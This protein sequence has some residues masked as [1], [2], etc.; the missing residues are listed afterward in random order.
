MPLTR[1]V[2]SATLPRD[3]RDTWFLLAV[4]GWIVVL[5]WPHVPAWCSAM[6][7]AV[8]LG[9]AWLAWRQRPLPGWPWRIALLVL[10]L[11]GTWASH[12]TWLGQ[13]AG[14]TLVM[15][16][17]ALK[18]LELRARRDA[19]VV[20]FLGFFALL[21]HFFHSQSLLTALGI[22]LA[23]L[24]LLSALVNAH[25]P[26]RRPSLGQTTRLAAGMALLGA[27]IM[28]LLFVLFPRFAPLWGLPSD[29]GLG[30]S[31]LSGHMRVGDVARL[32]LDDS[33][34]LRVE[35]APGQ[36]PP[37]QALYFR[38][39]VL[40]RFDGQQWLP[41][42]EGAAQ[43]HAVA[44]PA[45]WEPQG[46][47]LPYRLTQEPS[48]QTWVLTL[49]ATPTLP[50]IGGQTAR[51]SV[52]LDWTVPLPLNDLTRFDAVAYLEHRHGPPQRTPALQPELALPPGH[53]PRTLAWA[54][55]LRQQLAPDAQG[56]AATEAL[57]STVLQHLRS[58]GYRYTLEPGFYGRDSADAFWFD[59]KEGFC[60]HIAS[61]FVI[62][63]RALDIPARVVTGYQGGAL[64]PVDGVWTVRQSDAHA[65]AE[66][67]QAQRGWVRIDP[68]AHVMP[69]RTFGLERLR[70][71]PG[72]W[73]GTL[74][75]VNPT[76]LVHLR[77]LWEASNHHWNQWVLNYTHNRQLD[78]LRA[79]GFDAPDRNDLWRALAGV[80]GLLSVAGLAWLTLLRT[81][82]HPWLRLLQRAR[83]RLQQAGWPVPTHATPRQL[84][85]LLQATG[86][87]D[88]HHGAR[89]P[90]E[91]KR[92]DPATQAPRA[93]WRQWLLDLEACRYD[94]T[95]EATLP[96][97]VLRARWRQLPPPPRSNPAPAAPPPSATATT[98]LSTR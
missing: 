71:P 21:T 1:P 69:S 56:A 65:W 90:A 4:I 17:L 93:A 51:R 3:T 26:V 50:P 80:F 45:H 91:P 57:V 63:M 94:P 28:V 86:N 22:V 96:L 62:L 72:L 70:P 9:R 35:F 34:A 8:L 66:I 39:P 31:G 68:T 36:R 75:R 30:R 60:E 73:L 24:G 87:P 61:S 7:L 59:R 98:T 25:M 38:G 46:P 43:P 58:N 79:L 54:R 6:A 16:L 64:N 13:E 23:L 67:W 19:F 41:R 49:E 18:T 85:Q 88:G 89:Q 47:P 20:F 40:S 92:L 14:V 37:Q 78:M 55:Q 32:A 42:A 27:P 29:A 52:D 76:L 74:E 77:A 81:R 53:N 97:R 11:T 84:A 33:I 10:A 44:D 82:T 5:Q 83:R 48:R 95:A 12:R 15:V 2:F